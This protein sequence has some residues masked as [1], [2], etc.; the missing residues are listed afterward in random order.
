MLVCI[1]KKIGGVKNILYVILT[2]TSNLSTS[3]ID[4]G[5]TECSI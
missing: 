1:G 4:I 3:G 2:S 5:C